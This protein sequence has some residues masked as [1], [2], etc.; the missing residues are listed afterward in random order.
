MSHRLSILMVKNSPS[1]QLTKIRHY[2]DRPYRVYYERSKG[3]SPILPKLRSWRDEP[4]GGAINLRANAVRE[5]KKGPAAKDRRN[6][7]VEGQPPIR[8]SVR[9]EEG[10]AKPVVRAAL[11]ATK[12]GK[13][14]PPAP[15]RTL[16]LGKPPT[17][18]HEESCD[19]RAILAAASE[20][21]D[22]EF[23]VVTNVLQKTR[24]PSLAQAED[25]LNA[26]H[27]SFGERKD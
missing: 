7:S 21:Q 10:T 17:I 22:E 1:F 23:A 12:R 26:L 11:S 5:A 3:S 4:H 14:L 24:G 8:E 2:L 16:S 9:S 27:R 6:N 25:A 13:T 18:R 19:V 15:S 20:W